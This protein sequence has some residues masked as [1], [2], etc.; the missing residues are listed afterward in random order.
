MGL[1]VDLG[2]GIK[3][4]LEWVGWKL[5]FQRIPSGLRGIRKV[6]R[7]T[8]LEQH[9]FSSEDPMKSSDLAPEKLHVRT[10]NI[11]YTISGCSWA[12]CSSSLS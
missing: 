2:E 3:A 12:T 5:I 4:R 1:S 6:L 10:S 8:V 11:F 9:S 7:T